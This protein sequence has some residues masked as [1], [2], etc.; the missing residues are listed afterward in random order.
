LS[1][2]G[3]NSP[4][5]F[6]GSP[7]PGSSRKGRGLGVVCPAGCQCTS[8]VHSGCKGVS[9]DCRH[10][11]LTEV[12]PAVPNSTV[13]LKLPY[14]HFTALPARAFQRFTALKRLDLSNNNLM[15]IHQEAFSGLDRLLLLKLHHNNLSLADPTLHSN[16]FHGVPNLCTLEIQ[17]NHKDNHT[18]TYRG[19][20]FQSLKKLKYLSLDGL[21]GGVAFDKDFRS[22]KSL[23]ILSIYGFFDYI[24]NDTF[25]NFS[26]SR[27][28]ELHFRGRRLY[29]M[30]ASA[31]KHFKHLRVLSLSNNTELGFDNA[32]KSWYGLQY[33]NIQKLYLINCNPVYKGT[34]GVIR[35]QFYRHLNSTQIIELYLDRN[36]ILFFKNPQFHVH[37][38][39]LRLLSLSHNRLQRNWKELFEDL[40][41]LEHLNKV[42]ISHQLRSLPYAPPELTSEG[43]IKGDDQWISQ[44]AGMESHRS[45]PISL[46]KNL[47]IFLMVEGYNYEQPT[48]LDVSVMGTRKLTY[49]DVSE[50]QVRRAIGPINVQFPQNMTWSMLRARSNGLFYLDPNILSESIAAGLKIE[51][52]DLYDNKLG[53][54][55][56]HDVEGRVFAP[57]KDLVQLNLSSNEIKYLPHNVFINLSNLE[58]LNLSSNSLR[59][60]NFTFSHLL[61]LKKLDLSSNL[62]ATLVKEEMRDL[63]AIAEKANHT[64]WVDLSSNPLIC[65]CETLD[66]LHWMQTSSIQFQKNNQYVCSFEKRFITLE[67]FFEKHKHQLDVKCSARTYVVAAASAT[68]TAFITVVISIFLYR[69]R[70]DIKFVMLRLIAQGRKQHAA[71]EERDRYAFDAFVA[72]HEDDR[73]W[74]R[75]ELLPHIEGP[76]GSDTAT[77]APNTGPHQDLHLCL[78]FRDFD[79][80]TRI[81]ENIVEGIANSR[82][83]ILILSDSFVE[84]HWCRFE[85]EMARMKC[86]DEGRNSIV[87]VMLRHVEPGRMTGNLR[88]LVRRYSFLTWPNTPAE[89]ARFWDKLREAIATYTGLPCVCECGSVMKTD[90]NQVHT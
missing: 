16:I 17:E 1:Q 73:E 65:T 78:H 55:L 43:D 13:C 45:T 68:S 52:L 74:V 10:L 24:S 76:Q 83:T 67:T 90:Q 28:K 2:C 23:K 47:E 33:T 66:F 22:L 59:K 71:G 57:Y 50:N 75:E 4:L 15:A 19:K 60:I 62:Y 27:V 88:A 8:S 35:Q 79:A 80:G 84:S 3:D 5:T 12:P 31:F 63:D 21:P 42:S 77:T 36:D 26:K 54:Q 81:T 29:D 46:P 34:H 70:W 11:N 20:I 82:K 44:G 37:L 86:F 32:S 40:G 51:T 9:V 6:S 39:H 87:L 48:I 64:V 89:E 7:S 49:I 14:N 25:S 58:S 41:N 30:E 53:K 69:H 61:K 72:Y 56:S 18:F 85:T 38:P